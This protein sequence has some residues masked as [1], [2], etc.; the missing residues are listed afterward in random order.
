MENL[1]RRLLEKRTLLEDCLAQ[2]YD[3]S[4]RVVTFIRPGNQERAEMLLREIMLAL[5]KMDVYAAEL[6][7]PYESGIPLDDMDEDDVPNQSSEKPVP[8]AGLPPMTD[9]EIV[10]A[11][12]V[13]V[14]GWEERLEKFEGDEFLAWYDGDELVMSSDPNEDDE[15]SGW[16]PLTKEIHC[17]MVLDQIAEKKLVGGCTFDGWH[18]SCVF[19]T[20][21][22]RESGWSKRYVGSDVGHGTARRRS[23]CEAALLTVQYKTLKY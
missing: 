12:A 17:G 11:I 14:M 4:R 13:Q 6:D 21:F 8:T 22:S 1:L 19:A 16:N 9:E 3:A 15:E 5:N 7:C 2:R 18:W 20:F 10:R 23:V